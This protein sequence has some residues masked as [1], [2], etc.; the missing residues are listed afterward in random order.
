MYRWLFILCCCNFTLY[1]KA[2]KL[3]DTVR[4][5]QIDIIGNK[6]ITQKGVNKT[7]FDSLILKNSI[8]ANLSDVLTNN[9]SIFIKSYG[10]G[11]M[12]TASF[13]GTS[14]SHTQV[15]WND[16]PINSPMVGLVDLSLLP[17]FFADDIS[18]YYGSSSLVK[19]SGALGGTIVIENKADWNNKLKTNLA[20][21]IGSFKNYQTFL[22]I[23]AGNNYFQSNTRILRE[24]AENNY[25]FYNPVFRINM[26]QTN[27]RYSKKGIMQELYLRRNNKNLLSIKFWGLQNE[28]NMP[29]LI[30]TDNSLH[31]YKENQKDYSI[32]IVA[33]YKRIIAK[34][35]WNLAGGTTSS[36]MIYFRK[37]DV[38]LMDSAVNN[39]NVYFAKLNFVL[40]YNKLIALQTGMS[41]NYSKAN[42]Q[43]YKQDLSNNNISTV[44]DTSF[45]ANRKELSAFIRCNSQINNKLL[46]FLLIRQNMH[47][48]KMEPIIPSL[49]AEYQLLQNEKLILN[50]NLARNYHLPTLDDLYFVPG[51]NPKL[52]SEEGYTIDLFVNNKIEN[53]H[54]KI[55]NRISGYASYINNWIVWNYTSF[56]NWTPDNKQKVFAR[57]FE[58]NL[59]TEVSYLNIRYTLKANYSYTKTTSQQRDSLMSVSESFR[60]QL[61]YIP[62]HLYNILVEV[63]F[64][65]HFINYSINYT[66]N[67]YT[68]TDNNINSRLPRYLLNNLSLGTTL[69]D[70]KILYDIQF[71]V[72]NIFNTSYQPL[73]SRAMAGINYEL[74]LRINFNK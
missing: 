36:K 24:S 68:S 46:L 10:Q 34:G 15:L 25:P 8:N 65:K 49:G 69:F 9:S 59:N 35:Y 20:Q 41:V 3:S 21:G 18:L 31:T 27:S 44:L 55:T 39:S 19:G 17:V 63:K 72:N 2:Q 45:N 16:I 50:A 58:Y 23:S 67:R 30:T 64:K 5:V 60:K 22:S 57:G 37:E 38:H 13:R 53:E 54:F 12:A 62:F 51:G 40:S 11:G 56:Y 26:R 73:K 70:K 28:R 33:E 29:P 14:A 4:I 74:L 71:K 7:S 48:N 43:N 52:K 1:S 6:N 66:G 61:I 32:N 47:D 42:N